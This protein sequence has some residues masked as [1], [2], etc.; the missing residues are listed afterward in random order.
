MTNRTVARLPLPLIR[1]ENDL[2]VTTVLTPSPASA[3]EG[4]SEGDLDLFEAKF[5]STLT[6]AL[7]R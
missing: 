3:G 4:W 5:N 1:T 6:L 7:S 2:Q